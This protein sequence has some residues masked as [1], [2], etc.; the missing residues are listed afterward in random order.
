MTMRGNHATQPS[1]LAMARSRGA[2]NGFLLMLLGAWG[3]VIPFVG[4]FFG[5]GFTPDNTWTWTAARGWLEVL[6]GAAT[7][8]GGLLMT[9]SAHRITASIGG[10]LAAASGAWFVIGTVIAPVWSAGNIGV[11]VGSTDHAVLE[12][13]GMFDG[14]GVVIIFLAAVALGRVS[15]VSIR[16][17]AVA[18]AAEEDRVVE[19]P[20]Y[21]GETTAPTTTTAGTTTAAPATTTTGMSARGRAIDEPM[22]SD[23]SRTV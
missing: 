9:G 6:P 5:Y 19:L 18:P 23:S 8:V 7:F 22:P 13:I 15:V 1:R 14:L 4:H 17:G 3:A 21:P 12:R 11:P 16:D 2:F 10:W 20:S